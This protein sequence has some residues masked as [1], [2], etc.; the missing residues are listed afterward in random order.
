MVNNVSEENVQDDQD[1]KNN[2]SIVRG[3]KPLP[4]VEITVKKNA[5]ISPS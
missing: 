5:E 4:N 2:I 3:V 1:T